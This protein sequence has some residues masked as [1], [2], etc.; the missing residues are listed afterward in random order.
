M[1]LF[2]SLKFIAIQIPVRFFCVFG[3]F[4]V[5]MFH[6]HVTHICIHLMA[7]RA[8]SSVLFPTTVAF[9]RATVLVLFSP[10]K[11]RWSI[12]EITCYLVTSPQGEQLCAD[13][14]LAPFLK[15]VVWPMDSVLI[16]LG[17]VL[18]LCVCVCDTHIHARAFVLSSNLFPFRW[19][20]DALTSLYISGLKVKSLN[21]NKKLPFHIQGG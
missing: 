8:F 13:C 4:C 11:K 6:F 9:L 21:Q 14:C 15:W 17:N 16:G 7:A 1:R 10:N 19:A 3:W 20:S 2:P 5:S 12:R 18:A